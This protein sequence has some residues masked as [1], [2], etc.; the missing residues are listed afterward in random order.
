MSLS[1]QVVLGI[2]CQWGSS[3]YVCHQ[4][5]SD[6]QQVLGAFPSSCSL[7]YTVP[8]LAHSQYLFA[9]RN[10]QP[11]IPFQRL[12]HTWISISRRFTFMALRL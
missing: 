9:S 5:G 11:W 1:R 10:I 12:E 6:R 2:Q 7:P 8:T 4:Y 3:L